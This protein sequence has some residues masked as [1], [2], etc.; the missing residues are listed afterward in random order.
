IQSILI[1]SGTANKSF[2]EFLTYIV[3]HVLNLTRIYTGL[4]GFN[5][6]WV[7]N[8][9]NNLKTIYDHVILLILKYKGG[10]KEEDEDNAIKLLSADTFYLFD[11]SFEEY[12]KDFD[13]PIDNFNIAE[14]NFNFFK[15]K[16]NMDNVKKYII[17]ESNVTEMTK[18]NC[19]IDSFIASME[20][21][22][23]NPF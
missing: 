9:K 13:V 20:K 22:I 10:S 15:K 18:N 21:I 5:E 7:E 11:K 19:L 3:S 14:F 6:T 1:T 23:S 2:E 12:Y 8:I 16:L 4:R 17:T